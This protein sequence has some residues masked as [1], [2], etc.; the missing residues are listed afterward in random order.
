[1]TGTCE[2][3]GEGELTNCYGNDYEYFTPTLT[4][5]NAIYGTGGTARWTADL[6]FVVH[7]EEEIISPIRLKS[8]RK[9]KQNISIRRTLNAIRRANG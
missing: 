9:N 3:S 1:M 8:F 4:G 5:A 2:V 6:N 7:G